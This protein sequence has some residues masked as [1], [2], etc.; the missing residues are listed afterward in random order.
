MIQKRFYG[1]LSSITLI[2]KPYNCCTGIFKSD[3]LNYWTL[4]VFLRSLKEYNSYKNRITNV[5]SCF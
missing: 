1:V 4:L 5:Q 3:V 2:H